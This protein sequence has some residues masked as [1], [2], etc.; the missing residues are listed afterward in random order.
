MEEFDESWNIQLDIPVP[1]ITS[2]TSS[3]DDHLFD[4]QR[5][6]E[7]YKCDFEAL[8]YESKISL[9]KQSPLFSPTAD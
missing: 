5:L 8:G 1:D 7:I 9:D 6:Y 2:N 3:H 4:H